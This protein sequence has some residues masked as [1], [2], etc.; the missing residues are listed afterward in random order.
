MVALVPIS[1]P[2]RGLKGHINLQ[3]ALTI[4]STVTVFIQKTG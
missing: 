2:Q 1:V 4:K 3:S